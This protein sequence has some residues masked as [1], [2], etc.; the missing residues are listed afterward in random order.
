MAIFKAFLYNPFAIYL[1]KNKAICIFTST[2][3]NFSFSN[4]NRPSIFKVKNIGKNNF[5]WI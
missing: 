5:K 4:N 1:F 3:S 2:R